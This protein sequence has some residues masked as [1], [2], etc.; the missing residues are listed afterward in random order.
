MVKVKFVK[1]TE[2]MKLYLDEDSIAKEEQKIGTIYEA[3]E[4]NSEYQDEYH[5]HQY[6][7]NMGDGVWFVPVESCEVV[8]TFDRPTEETSNTQSQATPTITP[9]RI[10]L[11]EDGSVD[12]DHI[13]EDLGIDCIVYRSGANKPEWL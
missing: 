6:A 8:E 12:I 11:V 3:F 4:I 10:L 5:Q 1:L 9:S 2:E 7:L 13:E